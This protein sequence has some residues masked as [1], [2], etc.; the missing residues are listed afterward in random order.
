MK[1]NNEAFEEFHSENVLCRDDVA[2]INT[3][4]NINMSQDNG[5]C[6]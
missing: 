6:S 2:I 1:R 3:D 5:R 4:K